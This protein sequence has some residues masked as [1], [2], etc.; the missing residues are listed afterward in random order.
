MQ[1]LPNR[2]NRFKAG[3]ARW[4]GWATQS[5]YIDDSLSF[6]QPQESFQVSVGHVQENQHLKADHLSWS[7]FFCVAVSVA[8]GV[9][10]A[11]RGCPRQKYAFLAC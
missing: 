8:V 9:A 4:A 6:K 7:S 11:L 3:L 10:V 2:D 5:S 1:N